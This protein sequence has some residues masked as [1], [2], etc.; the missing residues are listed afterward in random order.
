MT[1]HPQ[2]ITDEQGKKTAVVLPLN[3]YEQI[4]DEL[5][6]LE[7]IKLF[8]EAQKDEEPAMLFDDYVNKGLQNKC[9]FT[10]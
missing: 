5:D 7:D 8:D 6:E 2:Y 10:N 1:L 3:E 9:L 4:L